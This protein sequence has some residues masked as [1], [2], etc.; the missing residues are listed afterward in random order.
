[1]ITP[2]LSFSLFVSICPLTILLLLLI[3]HFLRVFVNYMALFLQNILTML[4]LLVILMLTFLVLGP[5]ALI[6]PCSCYQTISFLLI[7]S[8]ALT[9]PT[10]MMISHAFPLLIT[11]LLSL[12]ILI[13]LILFLFLILLII[14]QTMH[15]SSHFVLE[16]SNF[17]SL[18]SNLC[19]LVNNCYTSRHPH[20]PA[21]SAV[22]R[23]KVTPCDVSPHCDQLMSTLPEFPTDILRLL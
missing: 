8:L 7:K 12:T 15:L 5:I 14:S 18:P 17:L 16:F 10:I 23:F 11:F 2:H 20:S 22:N 3:Q 6:Y 13:S 19:L 4:S 21:N 9:L 1:M